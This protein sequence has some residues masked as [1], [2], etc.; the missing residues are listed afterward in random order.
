M[1]P[2]IEQL[3]ELS[4]SRPGLKTIFRTAKTDRYIFI[5][6][7]MNLKMATDD[8]Q[9]SAHEMQKV[10]WN[11][12]DDVPVT[13]DNK[14]RQL[15]WS[16]AAAADA[17]AHAILNPR[18]LSIFV[19]YREDES[20][21]KIVY[22]KR[23]LAALSE[24]VP[25]ERDDNKETIEL[26]NGSRLMSWTCTE[27][28]GPG[29]PRIYLD[30]MAKYPKG[31]DSAIYTAA[32]GALTR[33]GV[34]R[35][36]STPKPSGKFRELVE[37]DGGEVQRVLGTWPWWTAP[38]LVKENQFNG[39]QLNAPDMTTEQRVIRYGGK[40]IRLLYHEYMQAGDIGGF[41]Q[42]FECMFVSESAALIPDEYIKDA[43]EVYDLGGIPSGPGII[44][45]GAD[46][47]R[48]QDRSEFI[49]VH[50][51]S[52]RS[53]VI[54]MDRMKGADADEQATR[55]SAMVRKYKPFAVYGDVTD[56][57]GAVVMKRVRDTVC[58]QA[59]DIAFNKSNK[60]ELA[61][62]IAG[63][64]YNH[65]VVIPPDPVLADDIASARKVQNV[66]GHVSYETRRTAAGH[67][68]A[69]WALALA[70]YALP[71][72]GSGFEYETVEKRSTD[73]T[74]EEQKH[75]EWDSRG[76][77]V[78]DSDAPSHRDRWSDF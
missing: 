36:G 33:G 15:G 22:A 76:R 9:A 12:T 67:G 56:G 66:S 37:G 20:K 48:K 39:A 31:R 43:T 72:A 3:R 77:S 44:A 13:L 65:T 34:V 74:R 50:Y 75:V 62:R 47:A 35:I 7:Y 14:A 8:E 2:L 61:K 28:R 69:F 27:P 41:Q 45:I 46:F 6:G 70:L 17:V 60:E 78:W 42:E 51:H 53:R 24:L 10:L 64:F 73:W 1:H 11:T 68:D 16:W 40:R 5:L 25:F 21:E 32:L 57:F 18:S 71:Q 58:P 38:H 23:C 52:G 59:K 4:R 55:L 19:S 49:A 26:D 29:K 54:A 63:A 30:E